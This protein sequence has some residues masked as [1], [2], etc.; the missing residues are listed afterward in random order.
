MMMNLT[1][2]A[3]HLSCHPDTLRRLE[4]SGLFRARRDRRGARRYTDG[5]LAAVQAILYSEPMF[6]QAGDPQAPEPV[7]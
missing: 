3:S 7:R 5:D 6:A 1:D 4:R 2:A